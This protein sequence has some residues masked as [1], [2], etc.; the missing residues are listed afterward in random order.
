MKTNYTL[1]LRRSSLILRT[2][3]ILIGF[4]LY[5]AQP[6]AAQY[7]TKVLSGTLVETPKKPYCASWADYN[8]DGFDDVIIV[9]SDTYHTS[10][11]TN[12]GDGTFTEDTDNAI[13]NNDGPSIACS[14]GDYN[15]DGNI[16]LYICNTGNNGPEASQNFLFRNDGNGV[17]TRITDGAIVTDQGWSLGA[18]WADYDNDGF[19]DLYVS[20]FTEANCLYH[21]NG[22]GTFAKITEG[23]IVTDNFNTYSASWADYDNDGFQ[24]L[25]VVN[26]FYSE[27]PG[28]NDCLYHNNGDGTFT[29]NTTALI[30]NDLALTQGASWGDFNNDGWLDLFVS[31]NDFADVKHNFLYKNNGAGN[32]TLVNA[33]P[34]IDGGASFGSAWLDMN[35]D[36]FLDLT[37]SNNG[38]STR[39]LNYL[40]LNNGDETFTNQPAD[41]ATTTPLRDYCSSIADYDHNGY[42]DIFTPSYSTTLIHG[43]YQNNGGSNNWLTVRLVGVVSNR[44]AIGARV[45]C[46]ANGVAQTR[47]VS[48]TSGQYCG[49]SLA[50]MFGIGAQASIDSITINWPSGIHQVIENP[51]INQILVVTEPTGLNNENNILTFVLTNQ[52]GAAVINA[53]NHTVTCEVTSGTNL[54][55]LAPVITVS[56]GATI[57]PASGATVDFSNGPVN[58]TVTAENGDIQ[59]WV[60]TVT[61][62][63]ILN[64]ENDILTFVLTNQTGAAVINA[65]N[66]TVTCEVTSGTNLS[67]LAP[68]I[69]VSNGATINPASGATVDFSNGP[70]NYTVTA[71]NGDIQ[72]WVVTVTAEILPNSET[73]IVAFELINQ[74]EAA[75]IDAVNHTVT[76]HIPFGASLTAL[77]PV[78]LVSEGASVVPA[79]GEAVDF[80]AGPVNYT[81]TAENGTDVQVWSVIVNAGTVGLTNPEVSKCAFNVYPN[82][83]AGNGFISL[84][85]AVSGNYMVTVFN[86]VGQV[87]MNTE[88]YLMS[89]SSD[90]VRFNNLQQ[91]V[92]MLRVAGMGYTA[93]GKLIVVK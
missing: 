42:P 37:V 15:N 41:E 93:S 57:N 90:V 46:Y 11:F 76:A 70:V 61:E 38:S 60:V 17:F 36:G 7:F 43:L 73:D 56:N 74:T 30:V 88:V 55:A 77:T 72:V 62:Q 26:Y 86:Q 34:S 67:A 75:V 53:Q 65:Q 33:A 10:L 29:K 32:F 64:N 58:Y 85:S 14:W 25:F 49:S 22:D 9:D 8:G 23:E 13:Y 51:S 89:G 80:S 35:N 48:S 39:R 16:D 52:T 92:Y 79:S 3:L 31:V 4:V 28:Q 5:L 54:S 63:V 84:N 87:I 50:Q 20:N 59:V 91:G 19:L 68:V 18:A 66:H 81:V 12:N 45:K 6:V 40:Y 2:S 44:S 69:T 27:L 1:N 47:E 82:P 83:S 71:E 21:N 78:V 24:D